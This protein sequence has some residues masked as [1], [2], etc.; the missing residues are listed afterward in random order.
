[1]KPLHI[2]HAR[3]ID[4]AADLD[5]EGG[6]ILGEDGRILDRG[7]HLREAGSGPE[8]A[9]LRDAGGHALA[10][11]LVDLRVYVGEPGARHKESYRSVGEAAAAGGVTT[12]VVQPDTDPPLDDPALVAFVRRR[13]AEVCKVRAH[14]M[15]AMTKGR[16]GREMAEYKFLLDAGA[17]ALTDGDRQISDPVV[18]RRCLQYARSVGALTVHHIQ[19]SALAAQ[20]CATESLFAGKLGL[21]EAPAAAEVMALERDLRLVELTGARYHAGQISTAAALEALRRAKEK[22]LPVS[23]SASAHHYALNEYDIGDFRSFCKVSP[24]LREE[25]DRAALEEAVAEGLID[26]LT[27]SHRPQDE[28]SKRLPYAQ[29]ATGS[30]GLETSLAAALN[31][32]HKELIGLPAL[33]RMLALRPAELL[34]FETGRL[35]PGAPGDLILVDLGAPWIVDR[36]ALRSKSKNSAFH[37]RRMQGLVKATWVGGALVFER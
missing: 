1:M 21:P 9:D 28:E 36:K 6:L 16:A 2:H 18:T 11:G 13:A 14:P 22:G 30:V 7:P 29:A 35:T 31:L 33:W 32:H 15:A 12:I 8:G 4:P 34:G 23:A 3:L 20:G 25:A 27:S 37:D 24:P 26:A 17:V 5:A 19:D 10:P